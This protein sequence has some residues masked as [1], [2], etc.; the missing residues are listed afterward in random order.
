[1]IYVSTYDMQRQFIDEHVHAYDK[2]I[3]TFLDAPVTTNTA[4]GSEFLAVA[5]HDISLAFM[6][7]SL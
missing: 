5:A 2:I 6:F 7:M 1:M 3:Q 4:S